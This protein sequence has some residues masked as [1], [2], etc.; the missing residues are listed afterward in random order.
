MVASFN[1]SEPCKAMKYHPN[2][3]LFSFVASI[4]EE[5]EISEG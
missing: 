3:K 2:K 4:I 5:E 1:I